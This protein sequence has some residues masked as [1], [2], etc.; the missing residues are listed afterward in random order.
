MWLV[1]I[2]DRRD[3][4]MI[5]HGTGVVQRKPGGVQGLGIRNEIIRTRVNQ[6]LAKL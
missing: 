5:W 1:W 3:G 2:V 6:L 4:G